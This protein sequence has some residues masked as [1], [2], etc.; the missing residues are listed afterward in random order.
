MRTI[1]KVVSLFSGAG[2]LDLGLEMSKRFKILLANEV[3]EAPTKTQSL[4]FESRK[5]LST[6]PT[7]LLNSS[8]KP[9]IFL[10]KVE[11]L[12]LGILENLDIDVVIG[13]PPCQ[14]FSVARGPSSHR[15]GIEVH[16]GKL[17]SYFVKSLIKLKPKA[18]IFE[19]V[20][21]L[22]TANKGIAY[23]TI[24]E[25]FT[26]TKIRWKDIKKVI[27]NNNNETKNILGYE[28]LFA[29][30]VDMS[31]LGVPQFRKRVLIIGLRNDIAKENKNLLNEVK[32]SIHFILKGNNNLIT[33]F[34]LTSIEVFEGKP[35][36]DIQEK[37]LEIMKEYKTIP[38]NIDNKASNDWKE[39]IWKKTSFNIIQDYLQIHNLTHPFKESLELAFEEHKDMLKELQ[40]FNKNV[41]FL[42]PSDGSNDF[43]NESHNVKERMRRIPPNEN[44]VF[45]KGTKWQVKGYGM[46]HIYRR[47]HPLKPSYTLLAYGGGGTWG[48]HYDISRGQ[49]TNRER[50]RLQTFPD[51]FL[52]SG[53]I[54]QK[55]AQI[56]E[57]VPPLAAKKVAFALADVLDEMV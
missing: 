35:L 14:D 18:F 16:R 47:I 42:S 9:F 7:K 53:N 32:S 48:Y 30:K 13:G 27:G 57:S 34:P 41:S 56:G 6:L 50:A 17:Y 38:N 29:D 20:P 1:Y 21:G 25:D 3:L 5:I 8:S 51:N 24:L 45:V 15:K 19:N 54:S 2:G 40:Y 11:D 39:K 31:K 33:K 4:N 36:P 37:Y 10:G 12:D 44:H 26:K 22:L 55:R 23:K 43:P 52:F 49:L 46:S 28:I